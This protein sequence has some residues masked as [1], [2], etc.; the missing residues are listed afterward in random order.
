MIASK[1]SNEAEKKVP[2]L[3]IIASYI[4]R[5]KCFG[6]LNR[7]KRKWAAAQLAKPA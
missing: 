6:V 1:H 4:K 5:Q 7:R 2:H 3:L